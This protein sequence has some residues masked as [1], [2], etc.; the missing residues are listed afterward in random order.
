M[1]NLGELFGGV[2]W[3]AKTKPGDVVMVESVRGYHLIQV[4]DMMTDVRQMAAQYPRKLT[5]KRRVEQRKGLSGALST[6][7]ANGLTYKVAFVFSQSVKEYIGLWAYLSLLG[8]TS[9]FLLTCL[10]QS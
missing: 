10:Y 9:P 2:V 5:T 3:G 4:V 6:N 7:N 1:R 8:I